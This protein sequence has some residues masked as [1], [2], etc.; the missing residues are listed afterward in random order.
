MWKTLKRNSNKGSR[1][2]AGILPRSKR[3]KKKNPL[4]R[5]WSCFLDREER[6]QNLLLEKSPTQ[7]GYQNTAGNP[8]GRGPC[9]HCFS[10]VLRRTNSVTRKL[11]VCLELLIYTISIQQLTL[12]NS[13]VSYCFPPSLSSSVFP[14][15][16]PQ[17]T[18]DP[19]NSLNI[20]CSLSERAYLQACLQLLVL[21][22][23]L[24]HIVIY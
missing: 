10:L 20:A 8:R 2:R 21:L 5:L 11:S 3:E 13:S 16:P 15:T 18:Y 23:F 1:Y 12:S 9:K 6:C 22:I 7:S 19:G 14:C 4:S 24:S 17:L